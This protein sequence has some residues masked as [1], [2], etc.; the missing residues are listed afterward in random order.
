M[1]GTDTLMPP[2]EWYWVQKLYNI[3][4]LWWVKRKN[5]GKKGD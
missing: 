4:I 5:E 1:Y 3:D 2:K